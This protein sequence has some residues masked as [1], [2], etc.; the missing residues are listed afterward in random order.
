MVSREMSRTARTAGRLGSCRA[1]PWLWIGAL[2]I[3]AVAARG[4]TGRDSTPGARPGWT[5]LGLGGGGA[6]YM[7]AISPADPRLMLLGCD[8]SGSYRSTDGGRNWEMIHYRQLTGTT[9]VRPIWHPGDP[10]VA[11]AV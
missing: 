8:M 11:F 10:E 2:L 3:Q 7:P 9:S 4:Q 5:P 6:M 1:M